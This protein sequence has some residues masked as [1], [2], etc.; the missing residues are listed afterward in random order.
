MIFWVSIIGLL[1]LASL[2]LITPLIGSRPSSESDNRQ[3]QNTTIAREKKSQLEQQ[4]SAGEI[5]QDEFD[6]AFHDLQTALALDLEGTESGEL[7]Q[8][9][10]W[11]IWV[12]LAI[13]PLLSFSLYFQFGE[14]RVIKNPG[15]AQL[16]EQQEAE[17][18]LANM[19]VEE[20]AELIRQRLREN[21]EDAQGWFML[22]R[23][24]MAQQKIDQAVAA[25]QRTY[26]LVGEDPGVMFMLADAL[27]MQQQGV[28]E[29]EPE[30]LVLRGLEISPLEP[31]GL[32]LAGLAAEQ[33]KDFSVARKF[34]TRLLPLIAN[35]P[36]AN[37]EVRRLLDVLD[38][39][40]PAV[41]AKVVIA[42][43]LA[44]EVKLAEKIR[45]LVTEDDTVF[46]YA[47]AMNGPPMPLAVKRL[48]VQDLPALVTL[49]DDDA[50]VATLKLS[51]YDQIIVGA[52]I[53]KS[54]NPIAQPGDLFIEIEGVDSNNLPP[55]L[56]LS[57]SQI[58]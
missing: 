16:S 35:D 25:Y 38:Q 12:V 11:A 37:Q 32:W 23:T 57:I 42:K 39:R 5:N 54:G 27:A 13:I 26:D 56:A 8:R 47:K 46:V 52:R 14:Y 20:M 18:A 19:S 30:Q 33:R 1:L 36:E 51:S 24:L 4:L 45:H 21:P 7:S 17:H 41:Q 43:T 53:S 2:I 31:D 29:G 10:K 50:M 58:K 48:S 34:W 3:Q 55:E 44:L 49:S 40:D 15:L 28:M 22:G 6:S 9:G